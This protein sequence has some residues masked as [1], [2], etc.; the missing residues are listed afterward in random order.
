MNLPYTMSVDEAADAV[1]AFKPR[2]VY[3]YHFRGPDG[4]SDVRRFEEL[5][6][7]QSS[8]VTIA[9]WYPNDPDA[10]SYEE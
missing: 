9:T 7:S 8:T 1:L 10:P 3:P 4:Y 6:T 2:H 5:V